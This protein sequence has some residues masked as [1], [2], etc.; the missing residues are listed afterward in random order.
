MICPE[1]SFVISNMLTWL[2]PLNTGRSASSALIMGSLFLVLKTVLL[3]VVP[4]LF[5]ELGTGKRLRTDNG[6][7]FVVGLHRSH[8]GG[9]R[10]AF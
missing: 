9:I 7:K 5:G 2:L 1:T 6:G 8:E 4:E 3:D 10:L